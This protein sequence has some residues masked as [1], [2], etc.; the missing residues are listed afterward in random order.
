MC[1]AAVNINA[2]VTSENSTSDLRSAITTFA[3]CMV[4]GDFLEWSSIQWP[5]LEFE[6]E[7][8]RQNGLWKGRQLLLGG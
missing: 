8:Y 4:R 3:A 1:C 7:A 2:L 5:R 6:H